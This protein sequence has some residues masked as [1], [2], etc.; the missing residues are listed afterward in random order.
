MDWSDGCYERIGTDV[1]PV[2]EVVV[3]A[4]SPLPGEHLVDLG[5]GDGNAALFAAERGARV[6]GIDP[7]KRLLEVA[8]TRAA[9]RSLAATF[10]EGAAAAMPAMRTHGCER[11][12]WPAAVGAH[13]D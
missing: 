5:C 6:T 4:A 12:D 2:A 13:R 3:D 7:A 11:H 9:E 8:A 1:L 10:L